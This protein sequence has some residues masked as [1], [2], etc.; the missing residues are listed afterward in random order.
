MILLI[1][2]HVKTD[3]AHAFGNGPPE[4]IYDSMSAARPWSMPAKTVPTITEDGVFIFG[5]CCPSEPC[6]DE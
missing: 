4:E 3:I 5:H 2:F 6:Y 1:L